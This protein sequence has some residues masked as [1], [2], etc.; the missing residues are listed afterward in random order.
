MP[1]FNF[2]TS[3]TDEPM[4]KYGVTASYEVKTT[5]TKDFQK[6]LEVS[7]ELAWNNRQL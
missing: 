7:G 6:Q 3:N 1:C 4:E 2:Y 5:V